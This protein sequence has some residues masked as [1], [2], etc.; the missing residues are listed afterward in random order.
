M[1]IITVSQLN[2]YMK[3][4][5]DSNKNL[6]GIYVRGE[7]SNYKRHSSGHAYMTLKDSGS[8]LKCVMFSSY[9]SRLNFEP[10]SGMKAIIFGKISVYERDGAYQLYAE[11]IVPDGIGELYAAYEQLKS[12]LDAEGYFAPEVK[13]PL[14]KYPS[15]IGVVTSAQGAAVRDIISVLARRYPLAEVTV[16]PALVQGIGAVQSIV[17]GVEYFNTVFLPD[18]II[19]GRGGGSIEDL[20]AFN[21]RLV[22]DAIY[23]SVVPVISAVGHETDFTIADFVA[24]LRAP[25]PSAAAELAVPDMAELKASLRRSED[26]IKSA[27]MSLV[28]IKHERLARVMSAGIKSVVLGK[29][30]DC[31]IAADS[32]LSDITRAY[33]DYTEKKKNALAGICSSLD[34]LSPMKVLMR[35]YSVASNNAGVI[36]SVESIKCGDSFTLT[37]SDGSVKCTAAEKPERRSSNG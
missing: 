34:A 11:M 27:L 12:Q 15:H 20:W 22:A 14:P 36:K 30:G 2:N 18:V 33:N 7:I 29:I 6:S 25:T 19:V 28:Q 1:P 4:F 23:K 16:Y 5:V 37:L 17:A 26:R 31:R 32:A 8:A 24:D 3:R 21:D 10:R 35:G 13:K 9:V